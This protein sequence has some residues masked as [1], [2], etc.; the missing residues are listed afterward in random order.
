MILAAPLSIPFIAYRV[1]KLEKEPGSTWRIVWDKF[2]EPGADRREAVLSLSGMFVYI[3]FY[4]AVITT[5]WAQNIAWGLFIVI[6]VLAIRWQAIKQA[7]VK[8]HVT[9]IALIIIGLF[10]LPP[11]VNEPKFGFPTIIGIILFISVTVRL[12]IEN[13]LAE[14]RKNT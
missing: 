14:H 1:T 11:L 5:K 3:Y 7:S 10:T 8:F 4:Q 9:N 12:T 6:V 13:A 2:A